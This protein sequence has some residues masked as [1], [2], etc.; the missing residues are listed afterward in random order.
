MQQ[1]VA[2]EVN[3]EGIAGAELDFRKVTLDHAAVADGGSDE[4]T[5]ARVIDGDATLV[6]N[7]GVGFAGLVEFHC[8]SAGHECCVVDVGGGCHETC[9]VNIAGCPDQHAVRVDDEDSAVC[10]QVAVDRCYLVA[11]DHAVEGDGA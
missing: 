8:A 9:N 6:F 2:V 3:A 5:E 10:L 4:Q 1:A 11:V 7:R